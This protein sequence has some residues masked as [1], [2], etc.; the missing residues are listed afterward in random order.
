[1]LDEVRTYGRFLAAL[2]RYLRDQRSAEDCRR[3]LTE[4]LAG[5]DQA[6][7]GILERG[8]YGNPR[9][10]YRKLL[11]HAGIEYGDVARLVSDEGAEAALSHLHAAG[12]HVALEEFKCRR[13]ITRPGLE[14][15]V[16]V[17]DFDNPLLTKHY[18]LT[19]G[20][21]RSA[22]R[23]TH[24]DLDLLADD[25]AHH[26]LLEQAHG[27]AGRA[28][29][30]WHAVPPA[31]PGVKTA[32]M[33]AKLGH[34]ADRWFTPTGF[35]ARR[36]TLRFVAFTR[37]TVALSRLW[38][39][40]V[41]APE[42]VPP[43][44]AVRVARWLAERKAAGAPAALSTITSL[45]VRVALAAREHGLDI[46]GT[47]FRLHAEP[48]TPARAAIIEATGSRAAIGYAMSE[49]GML[50]LHCAEPSELDD[51]HILRDK[52]AI[53]QRDRRLGPDGPTVGA[54]LFTTLL[55]SCPKLM[56]NV[57]VGDYGELDERS[58]G[59]AI[60]AAG[61]PLHLSEIR[62]YDKLTSEGSTFLGTD[63][64]RLVE[65]TLPARFGGDATDYQLVEEEQGGLTKVLVVVSP[66]VGR[67]DD[68]EVVAT[69][70][71]T[72]HAN[73]DLRLMTDVWREGDAVR[74]LRREPYHTKVGKILPLHIPQ[75]R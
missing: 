11:E 12:V 65:E 7:L 50:G 73:P 51:V 36:G 1:V 9:S 32:L 10:P 59:C 14:I 27:V 22:G 29:A 64:I 60:G 70:L 72:L 58:C 69:V 41:P 6:F 75:P 18:E 61:L 40:P 49:L 15:P 23:R 57:D 38:G 67:L 56:I 8:V 35:A 4:L 24:L 44:D 62:S 5:R 37:S 54:L 71:G 43:A 66:A 63:L 74:V 30:I 34:P 16:R 55:P 53:L 26:S 19:S 42:Y 28:W 68:A 47:F 31:G 25:A 20:G 21:S 45:A 46:A 3:R 39:R 13:P 33:L 52:V 2:R 17:E 48:Y